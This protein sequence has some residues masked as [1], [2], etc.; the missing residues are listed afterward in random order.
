MPLYFALAC[1][2]ALLGLAG[3]AIVQGGRDNASERIYKYSAGLSLALTL[4]VMIPRG[5]SILTTTLPLGIP[6]IG[7][8]FR[9]DALSAFFVAVIGIGGAAASF[10]GVG[11]GAHEKHPSRVLPFFPAFIAGMTSVVLADDAFTFLVSWEFMSLVSWA[12]VLTHHE[13][14]ENR[15]AA[16]IYLAMASFGTLCLLMAFGVLG[17]VDG[18][19]DFASIREASRLPWKAGVVLFLVTLGAGSKAGLVP[20]HIWLP[21]AHPAAPSHVSALM[22][23]VMTKIAV[24]GFIRVAFDLLGPPDFLWSIH[25]L[26]FG[27]L[28]ALVGVLFATIEPDLKR[29]LAYST[30]ENIGIIFIALGLA[31]AFKA[32]GQAVPAALAFTAALLHVFNHMLFKSTLFFGAGAVLSATGE[33]NIERLGGLIHGMPKTAFL[34][35]G[36]CVAIA[37][38]PPMNGFVSEWLT[39]Q[40]I[41][42]SPSL[43]Q[44]ILRLIVPAVGVGLALTAA[45]GA[46]CYV[47]AFGIAFLG[48]P[49]SPA[50]ETAKET[51]EW[52]LGAMAGL[53][54][55]CLLAGVLPGYMIDTISPA[56]AVYVGGRMPAQD[57][58]PWMTIAP[59]AESRSLYNG[60]LVLAFIIISSVGVAKL[61]HRYGSRD[62]RRGPAWGCGYVDPSP[63]TQYS[64]SSFAQPVRRAFGAFAFSVH[65]SLDMPLPGETRAASFTVTIGDRFMRYFY[66]PIST[67]VW[68]GAEKLNVVNFLSIQGYLALVFVALVASLIIIA[69]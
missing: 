4:A 44:W 40:A 51:D 36:G 52:S 17:G 65:E 68:F 16:Y 13:D 34:F 43:P 8:H 45:L 60:L 53:F 2:G 31:L 27:T 24:Y 66:T 29:L 64:A 18:A 21:L 20:L 5:A 67:A 37:A 3:F 50:A 59:I 25:P 23:G 32:N 12:L 15:K 69:L 6:W 47:R 35:L 9:L 38:L 42:L 56:A 11:Y 61:I 7:M 63:M 48:R 28:S 10:Y 62:T 19:Y 58:I 57:A 49:R 30:I 46:G 54:A 41:L 33:R 14:V 55:L 26:V 39:F 22:S 1:V